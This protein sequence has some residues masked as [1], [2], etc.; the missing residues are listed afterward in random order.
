VIDP[1]LAEELLWILSA[2]GAE[3]A[4]VYAQESATLSVSREGRS[5]AVVES[6]AESGVSLLVE[7][8]GLLRSAGVAG[9]SPGILREVARRMAAES[10]SDA[11]PPAGAATEGRPGPE[12]FG[13]DELE[14]LLDAGEEA[15][16]AADPRVA[17]YGGVAASWASRVLRLDSLGSRMQRDEGRVTVYHRAL[18]RDGAEARQGTRVLRTEG[19][20]P[21]AAASA[22]LAAEAARGASLA[23]EARPCPEGVLPVVLSP[24]AAGLLFHEAL[25][26]LLEADTVLAGLSPFAGR[27]GETV[28]SPALTL[29]QAVPP[30]VV[31]L[32]DEGFGVLPVAL[33][34]RGGLTAFL[35]D[36]RTAARGGWPRTGSGRRE[37]FRHLPLP[38]TGWLALEPGQGSLQSLLGGLELGLFIARLGA[39]EVDGTSG[40]FRFPAVEAFLVREGETAEPVA[41]AAVEGMCA[42]LPRRFVR[43]GG[44]C[45]EHPGVSRKGG[46]AV[47]VCD[48]APAVLLEALDVMRGKA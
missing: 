35:T 18:A 14:A 42:D 33:V 44:R 38:R 27:L 31:A 47:P 22:D 20:L 19:A 36:R 29:R 34:E 10:V 7:R 24:Q 45:E 30:G 48:R 43:A 13:P 11:P 17:N 2:S 32:D 4:E 37:S 12:P 16:R 8:E 28:G 9:A 15:A 3:F 26:R 1:S 23:L 46:Q 5:A 40:R 6:G 21:T 39:G 41:G 25:G